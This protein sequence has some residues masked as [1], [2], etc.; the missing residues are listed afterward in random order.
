MSDIPLDSSDTTFVSVFY[1]L[2]LGFL[3]L[4]LVCFLGQC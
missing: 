4:G 1:L 3:V 2:G